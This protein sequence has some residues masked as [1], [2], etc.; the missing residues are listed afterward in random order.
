MECLYTGSNNPGLQV[1][2]VKVISWLINEKFTSLCIKWEIGE[3][4]DKRRFFTWHSC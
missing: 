2:F 3:M 1:L 4:I